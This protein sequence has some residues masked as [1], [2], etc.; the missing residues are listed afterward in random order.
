VVANREVVAEEKFCS[1]NLPQHGKLL[2]M[3]NGNPGPGCC[4]DKL[5]LLKPLVK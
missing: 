2:E 4:A 5:S 1:L 3:K